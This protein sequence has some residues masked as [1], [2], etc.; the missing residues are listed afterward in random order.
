MMSLKTTLLVVTCAVAFTGIQVNES[1]KKAS[2]CTVVASPRTYDKELIET[3]VLLDPSYHSLGAYDPACVPTEKKDTMAQ[4]VLPSSWDTTTIGRKLKSILSR[5]HKARVGVIGTFYGSGGPYGPDKAPFRI[6]IE[7]I[8][9]V[10]DVQQ[11]KQSAAQPAINPKTGNP[12]IEI[13][14]IVTPTTH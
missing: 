11:N 10:K 3:D 14:V 4:A 12:H 9:S 8:I 5:E 13:P 6:T 2:F 7:R 1:P